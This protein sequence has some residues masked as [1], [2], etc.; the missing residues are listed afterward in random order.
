MDYWGVLE[1]QDIFVLV[2][3]DMAVHIWEKVK[4]EDELEKGITT[5]LR[6]KTNRMNC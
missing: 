4:E 1:N 3:K 6:K 2:R 5:A